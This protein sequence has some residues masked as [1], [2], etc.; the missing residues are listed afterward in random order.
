MRRGDMLC[1][2]KLDRLG[3]SLK[4][5][6]ET[7]MTL[8]HAG[9]GF[10]SLQEHIDTTTSGGSLIF[11]LFASLAEFERDLI[12]ERTKGRTCCGACSW[13]TWWKATNVGRHKS[14]NGKDAVTR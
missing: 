14:S 11:H 3:R 1:V 12:R 10:R 4:Q 5:L 7:V 13:P 6:I 2:W 9:K 8:Q